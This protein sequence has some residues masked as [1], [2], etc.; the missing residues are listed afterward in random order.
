MNGS[1]SWLDLLKLTYGGE[2]AT[3]TVITPLAPIS[4]GQNITTTGTVTANSFSGDL[5]SGA[6][7]N[8][9]SIINSSLAIGR[10]AHNE[11]NFGT[12][13]EIVFQTNDVNQIYL[14]NNLFGPKNDSDVDLGTSAVRF[15]DTYF[16]SV[17][18][19]NV[20]SGSHIWKEFPFIL[21]GAAASRYFFRD[22]DD[23]TSSTSYWDSYEAD[24][25]AFNY[26][27]VAGQFMVPEN[28]TLTR[29][30]GAVS[31]NTSTVNPYIRVYVGT[32]DYST[33]DTALEIAENDSGD[34]IHQV[35]ISAQYTPVAIDVTY[36]HNLAAGDIVVPVVY[37]GLGLGTPNFQGSISLCFVTR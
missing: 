1:G 2:A 18:T 7:N 19:H 11:I 27:N 20:A 26:R 24:M 3:D 15:K 25:T 29:M 9:T 8:I 13:N 16:D 12:D 14:T 35:S 5:A 21:L 6:Q 4:S 37:R 36:N 32:P 33:S 23:T 10:D 30:V 22:N 17:N 28:C 31:N 34:V